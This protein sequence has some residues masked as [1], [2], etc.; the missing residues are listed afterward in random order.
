MQIVI[1]VPTVAE[2][3]RLEAPVCGVP[4]LRR[5]I[6]TALRGGATKVLLALPSDWPR[7]WLTRTLRWPP[8]ESLFIDTVEIG[9]SFDP[10]KN[11]DWR[12]IANCLDDRF[13]WIPS[14][15]LPHRAALLQLLATAALHPNAALRFCGVSESGAAPSEFDQPVV[16]LKR[17][18]M[19]GLPQGFETAR[20]LAS[21]YR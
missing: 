19:D 12:A 6:A 21:E 20:R 7:A 11:E 2:I 9:R 10:A 18:L 3:G 4:L 16:L 13:L 17:E 8:I 15:Y 1:A 14:D 5:L